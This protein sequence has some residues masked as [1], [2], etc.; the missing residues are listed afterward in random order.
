MGRHFYYPRD[1]REN[2]KLRDY[3]TCSRSHHPV[4]HKL[5]LKPQCLLSPH[6]PPSPRWADPSL[7]WLPEIFLPIQHH[8]MLFTGESSRESP[9]SGR[10]SL[11]I[12]DIRTRLLPPKALNPLTLTPPP[13]QAAKTGCTEDWLLSSSA[14]TCDQVGSSVT[15]LSL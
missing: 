14:S 12:A 11:G 1:K 15:I 8:L 13:P 2:L 5:R 4:R 9:K 6:K 3:I 7:F 10:Q